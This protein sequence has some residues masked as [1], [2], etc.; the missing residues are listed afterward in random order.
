MAGTGT[1][2]VNQQP[3]YG[4]KTAIDRLKKAT[5]TTPMTGNV[6]PAPTAG[7][8]RTGG[9]GQPTQAQ[10]QPAQQSTQAV[11]DEHRSAMEAVAR[12]YRT[13]QFW[14]AVLAESPS[15]WSRMYA[16][17]ANKSYMKA[18]QVL[19]QSTPYFE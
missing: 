9:A 6:V 7:R 2:S 15:E 18:S 11:P 4:D 19:R 13:K 17:D 10:E 3:V 14:D 16:A 12:A 1:I 5:T 8:P